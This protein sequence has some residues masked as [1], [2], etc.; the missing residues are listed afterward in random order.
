[1]RSGGGGVVLW[2]GG[3]LLSWLDLG[4]TADSVD[5]VFPDEGSS[6]KTTRFRDAKFI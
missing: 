3:D 5:H 1:V 6:A 4:P 2:A